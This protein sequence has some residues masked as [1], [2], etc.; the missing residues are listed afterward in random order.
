MSR[1]RSVRSRRRALVLV[2]ALLVA[3]V[4]G[5]PGSAAASGPRR[6]QA[7]TFEVASYNLYLG[8]DLTPLFEASDPAALVQVAGRVWGQVHA[9]NPPERMAA[10][11]DIL[12]RERPDLVGLQEVA[13]WEVA[14]YQVDP[15]T[16]LPRPTGPYQVTYDF[17]DLLLEALAA[18][19]TPY[20]AVAVEANF[21]S[22]GL[23]FA[24]PVS[25]TEAVRFTDH[26][27]ILVRAGT[28]RHLSITA[29]DGG[30]FTERFDVSVLGIPVEVVRGWAS[31][32]AT[33]RGRAFRL[34]NTHL[35]AYGRSPLRDEVRNPQAA[36]LAALVDASPSPVIVVGDLNARPTRC[37]NA[38]R[39][40]LPED[41]N[42]EAYRIMERAGLREVWPLTHRSR[43]CHPA[44][45][46]SGQSDLRGPDTRTHR[47]DHIFV[48]RS[49]VAHRSEVV[50][51]EREERSRP[52][53][54]W[55]SDHAGV[56]AT[57][58]LHPRHSPRPGPHAHPHSH[59]VRSDSG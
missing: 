59:A 32:D 37:R 25:G 19:G 6:D 10:V 1:D 43:P 18:R 30:E 7:G 31:V 23:P 48:D 36:E 51:D 40:P 33:F 28:R 8:A 20:E 4:G 41:A 50:G 14:P 45:W 13:R 55:P 27:V 9:S 53:G 21:S 15:A 24:V 58:A 12:A 5:W 52:S 34:F 49:F 38:R 2:V 56:T 44:S 54:L 29:A 11:A 22:A 35:E 3:I 26:D 42:V 39:P 46:T 16:S 57:L 47:I 17:L